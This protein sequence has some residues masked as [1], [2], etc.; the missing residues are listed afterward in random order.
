MKWVKRM[1]AR[2]RQQSDGAK[3]ADQFLREV[4]RDGTE[5]RKLTHS[6]RIEVDEVNHLGERIRLAMEAKREH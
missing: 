2:G 4:R 3:R 1:F 6:L 5:V